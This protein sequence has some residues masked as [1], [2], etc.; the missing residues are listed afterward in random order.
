[1]RN[2]ENII[3]DLKPGQAFEFEDGSTTFIFK[4]MSGNT[5][6]IVPINNPAAY[7]LH[8]KPTDRVI[9]KK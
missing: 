1:M 7:R 2:G 8:G 9:I 4:G 5:A 6:K 3:D